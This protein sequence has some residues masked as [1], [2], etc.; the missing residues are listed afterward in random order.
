MA[1]QE[2]SSTVAHWDLFFIQRDALDD[3][4]TRLLIRLRIAE[5]GL[6]EDGLVL[7]TAEKTN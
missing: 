7:G 5:I 6:L 1:S 2:C 4:K 3:V